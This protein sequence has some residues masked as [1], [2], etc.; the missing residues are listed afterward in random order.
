ML[1]WTNTTP[2]ISK[3]G[4]LSPFSS[5]VILFLVLPGNFTV[6]GVKRF[7]YYLV[8]TLNIILSFILFTYVR[9]GGLSVNVSCLLTQNS[10]EYII[11]NMIY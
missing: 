7:R 2:L 11:L 4:T 10:F 8:L 9:I 6:L 1:Q 5:L 3:W